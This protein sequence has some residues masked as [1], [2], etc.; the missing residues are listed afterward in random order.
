[1]EGAGIVV[2][3]LALHDFEYMAVAPAVAHLDPAAGRT[4]S[5]SAERKT[6]WRC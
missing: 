2:V 5:D 4:T 3:P 1:M 6:Q